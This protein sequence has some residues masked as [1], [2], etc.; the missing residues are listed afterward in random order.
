[1]NESG[2]ITYCVNDVS[3]IIL[4]KWFKKRAHGYENPY[5][6]YPEKRMSLAST[7]ND[8]WGVRRCHASIQTVEQQGCRQLIRPGVREGQITSQR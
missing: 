6:A 1:M 8:N 7:E 4:W 3:L 2:E 5:H